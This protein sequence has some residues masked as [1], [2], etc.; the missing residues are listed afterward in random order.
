MADIELN[1]RDLCFTF[2]S[3]V[4]FVWLLYWCGTYR[5][6]VL[7]NLGIP[8]PEPWPFLGSILEVHKFG[9]LHVML[10]EN[11]KRYG[12]IFAVCLGRSPT[13]VITEPEV[14]KTILVKEFTSFR[15]RSDEVKPPPPLNCGLLAA[16]DDQ[17]KRIRSILSPSYTTGKMKQMIPLMDDAVNVLIMK[18]DEVADAE[19]SVEVVELF[20]KLT[21]DVILLTAFGIKTDIQT[22]PQNSVTK[23][24]R[25]LFRRLWLTPY[26][27][28][29]PCSS[30]L[31]RIIAFFR[32][33]LAFFVGAAT[34]I[35]EER[36][37][38]ATEGRNDLI[39]LLLTAHDEPAAQGVSKLSDDEVIAQLITFL[40][41]GYQTSS[42]T[43]AFT[44]YHLAMD[45]DV[46]ERLR[47]EVEIAIQTY[48]DLPLYDLVHEIEYLDCVMNESMRLCPPLHI[49][50]RKCEET[51]AISPGLTIPAGMDVTIP[52]YALHHDPEAWPDPKVYDPERFRGPAKE[53]RHPFQ[54]LPF[55]AGPRN[56]IGMKYAMMEIKVALVRILR[57]FKFVRAPD[58]QVP[59]I[60]HSGVTLGPRDGIHLRVKRVKSLI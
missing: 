37:K 55:G 53:A 23:E 39:Q 3:L 6:S 18:L 30:L 29:F 5:F 38:Y 60:L 46:Q 24:A 4:T 48:H 58:T 33:G 15:N 47:C 12:K 49:F 50:N 41:A 56:C 25:K 19:K 43:L 9:G 34:E 40:L 27:S 35:F 7:K 54:F 8:G 44:A 42:S 36:K 51:C 59:L 22:D 52:V 2:G 10:L 13:I 21:L 20:S 14:L 17:W 32:Q 31:R 1:L 57:K 45:S 26:L 11:M 16:R 28:I